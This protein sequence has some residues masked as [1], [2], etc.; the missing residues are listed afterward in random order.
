M[1]FEGQVWMARKRLEFFHYYSVW[2]L[3]LSLKYSDLRSCSITA[4]DKET[5]KPLRRLAWRE[6]HRRQEGEKQHKEKR[7]SQNPGSICGKGC[8]SS[9]GPLKHCRQGRADN[10]CCKACVSREMHGPF[11]SS[12]CL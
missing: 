12:L 5:E 1:T 2:V 8:H 6:G 4:G 11:T 3:P 9:T 7:S 10:L